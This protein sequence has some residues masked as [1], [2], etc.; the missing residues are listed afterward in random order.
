MVD[1]CVFNVAFLLGW[2][3]KVYLLVTVVEHFKNRLKSAYE[4]VHFLVHCIVKKKYIHTFI[5][6]YCIYSRTFV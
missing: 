4:R 1:V 5:C 6:L 3:L 2:D